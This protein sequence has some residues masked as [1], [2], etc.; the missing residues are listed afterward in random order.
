MHAFIEIA[1]NTS[2]V[3]NNVLQ[4]DLIFRTAA[5]SNQIVFSTTSNTAT[6]AAATLTGSNLCVSG[7]LGLGTTTPGVGRAATERVINV[8]NSNGAASLMLQTSNVGS[9]TAID[10]MM[11]NQI[12]GNM[13]GSGGQVMINQWINRNLNLCY[14]G[15][16]VHVGNQATGWNGSPTMAVYG[17]NNPA[18]MIKNPNNSTGLCEISFDKMNY[19]NV[20]IGALGQGDPARGMYIW[21]NGADRLN[22]DSAGNIKMPGVYSR[23]GSATAVHVDTSGFL[24]RF[25][26][27]ERWKT[28]TNSNSVCYSNVLDL[29]PVNFK[30][31]HDVES[32]GSNAKSHYGL[33]AEAVDAAGLSEL[34]MYDNEGLPDSIEYSTIGVMLLPVIKQLTQRVAALEAA[35]QA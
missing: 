23:T 18:I 15:G 3:N 9:I 16:Q 4:D 32:N 2:Y 13:S 14:G 20:C 12:V 30:Y 19:S 33:I 35:S 10:F 17:S 34:V 27:S 8:F 7:N 6:L 22:I 24:M 1:P 21:T 29:Q 28:D 26:S 25:S 31:K 5:N 11:S